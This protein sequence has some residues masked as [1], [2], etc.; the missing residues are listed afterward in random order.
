MEIE[1]AF[2][3][4][5]YAVGEVHSNAW[6]SAYRG[7]FPDEYI[8][9]DSPVKRRNEF[10]ES[11]QSD[12]CTYLV[13]KDSD[14]IVGIVKLDKCTT[15]IEIESIYILEEYR[16]KSLGKKAIDHIKSTWPDK[17][18]FL[19]VLE[20][21]NAARRFYEKNGFMLTNDVRM[22]QRGSAFKQCRYE[23]QS[24]LG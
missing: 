6:K 1:I 23:L 9:Q 18:I 2:P 5:A 13:I 7:I 22:I 19:W 8:E 15:A 20:A 12:Q 3:K 17:N 21:N 14:K 11:I 24:Y 10:L 16:G 4:D